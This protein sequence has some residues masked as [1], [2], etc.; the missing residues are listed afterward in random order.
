MRFVQTNAIETVLGDVV[1]QD[2][3]MLGVFSK[4]DAISAIVHDDVF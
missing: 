4:I 3:V 1:V 2:R